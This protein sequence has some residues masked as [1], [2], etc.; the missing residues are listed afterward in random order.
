MTSF[1]EFRFSRNGVAAGVSRKL[2]S[3]TYIEPST[4]STATLYGFRYTGPGRSSRTDP[5]KVPAL[6]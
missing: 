5:T 2:I 6:S 4:L 3:G 1:A